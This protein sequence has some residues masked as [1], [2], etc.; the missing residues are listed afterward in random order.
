MLW[1]KKLF[2][3]THYKKKNEYDA[4]Q[5][6]PRKLLS[7]IGCQQY[8]EEN[9]AFICTTRN[10]YAA[11]HFDAA[12]CTSKVKCRMQCSPYNVGRF[13]PSIISLYTAVQFNLYMLS[14]HLFNFQCSNCVLGIIFLIRFNLYGSLIT[15]IDFIH[16][17][18]TDY[19]KKVRIKRLWTG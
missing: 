19:N 11:V 10:Q 2:D 9:R 17:I 16:T 5:H 1:K 3:H 8:E 7:M 13:L 15:Y 12:T 14:N 4:N 18:H 6:N